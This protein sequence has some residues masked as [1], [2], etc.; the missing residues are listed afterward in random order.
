MVV[1][2]MFRKS[3]PVCKNMETPSVKQKLKAVIVVIIVVVVIVTVIVIISPGNFHSFIYSFLPHDA[4]RLARSW[5]SYSVRL[6]VRSSVCHTCT[7]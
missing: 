1:L 4:I 2:E 5:E 7:L 3:G 6:S